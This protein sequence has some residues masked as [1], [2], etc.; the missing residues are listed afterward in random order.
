MT[1]GNFDGVHLGHRALV[2]ACQEFARGAGGR[3]VVLAF[4]PH[5]MTTLRPTAAPPRLVGFARKAALLR[6]AGADVVERLAPTPALLGMTAQ[7]FVEAVFAQHTPGLIVEGADFH[8][9]KGRGG[10]NALLGE[11]CAARRARLEVVPAV[12]VTLRDQSVA[13]ASS[14]LV[15]ALVG[16]GRVRD[17][18]SV[19]GRPYELEGVVSPGDRLGRSIGVPTCNV[20]QQGEGTVAGDVCLVPADGVYAGVAVLPT[21]QRVRCAIHVGE[22]PTVGGRALRIEAHLVDERGGIFAMPGG[23]PEYGWVLR[24]E[25]VGFVRDAMRL[26]GLEALRAQIGRDVE[27]VVRMV[28]QEH[29]DAT[30]TRPE[31]TT[32]L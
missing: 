8:F 4:D 31:G 26:A 7:E 29:L 28:T 19:L 10:N 23:L 25:F 32:L 27:R 6:E 30:A 21:A 24:L 14:T 5:P 11:M 12:E 16:C 2:A 17:A 15:R 20:T 13:R 18:A 3:V 22:R 9:G 1:I